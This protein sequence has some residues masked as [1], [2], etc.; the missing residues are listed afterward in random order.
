MSCY[1]MPCYS[2]ELGWSIQFEGLSYLV[3][4]KK[5]DYGIEIIYHAFDPSKEYFLL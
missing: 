1:V 5:L 3:E 2:N 4:R